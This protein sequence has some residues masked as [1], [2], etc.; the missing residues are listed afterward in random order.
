MSY[1]SDSKRDRKKNGFMR[2]IKIVALML[3]T[4]AIAAVL[5]FA[6]GG[7]K[8]TNP[9]DKQINPDNLINVNT[10]GYIKSMKSGYGVSIDVDEYGAIKLSG[11]A[12]KAYSVTVATV[13]LDAG[14]YTI[15]GVKDAN[16]LDQFALR[17]NLPNGEAAWANTEND[18][19]T[20]TEAQTVSVVLQ[21]DK[22]YNFNFLNPNRKVEPV[23]VKGDTAG[24][25]YVD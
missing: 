13:A 14:T 15:S 4:A 21:W 23:L 10:E 2:F 19:F 17:V 12:T 3:A 16:T 5:V 6:F 11:K 9:F 1:N 18:T 8:F 20:L 25:F 24:S 22:D 7:L